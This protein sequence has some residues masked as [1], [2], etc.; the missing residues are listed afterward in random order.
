VLHSFAG[1]GVDAPRPYR[2]AAVHQLKARLALEFAGRPTRLRV[3]QQDPPWKVVRAFPDAGGGVLVHLHNVSGG[4]LGGDQLSLEISAAAGSR[5]QITSTGA[6][7]LYRQRVGGEDSLQSV[8]IEIGDGAML[9]YLPDPLIP[10]AGS[11]HVQRTRVS[12]GQE[13]MLFWW[14][15]IAPGRRA[16]GE[17]FAF[18]R[19]RIATSVDVADRPAVREAFVME[20]AR[21]SP[22]SVAR[23]GRFEYLATF[24]AMAEGVAA[25]RWCEL[26]NMLNERLSIERRDEWWG[27]STL[28]NSGVVVRGLTCSPRGIAAILAEVWG[29]A[30]LFLTGENAMAPR[31]VY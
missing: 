30:R 21:R 20:P 2:D 6:T 11:Q 8:S 5:V 25:D 19:L 14:E 7:R 13:A 26:E 24:Y 15:T 22:G 17:R 12:L 29:I 3:R 9:E 28:A 10:F 27:A 18:D 4:V 31:K 16:A 23:M 1:V